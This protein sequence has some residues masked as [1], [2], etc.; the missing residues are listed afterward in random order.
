MGIMRGRMDSIYGRVLVTSSV[1][2]RTVVRFRV[3]VE[4]E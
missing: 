3:P 1:S 2:E 4:R